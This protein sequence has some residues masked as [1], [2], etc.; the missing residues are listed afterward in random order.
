LETEGKL[1][2]Y[3]ASFKYIFSASGVAG[4]GRFLFWSA[5]LL[6][7]L[8]ATSA[9]APFA[10]AARLPQELA[11]VPASYSIREAVSEPQKRWWETFEDDELNG[12]IEEAFAGNQNLAS[13]WARL[14]KAQALAAKAG[15]DFIP[16][17]SGE[18]DA[19]YYRSR[20]TDNSTGRTVENKNYSL[21]LVAGYEIDLWGRIRAETQSAELAAAASRQDL[22]GAAV[23]IAA[24][25][26]ERWA[27]IIAQRQ[28]KN[29]L[30]KQL[31]ANKTYQDLVEL[32]FRKSLASALDV[33]QQRQLV[34]RVKAGIPL[35]EMEEQLLLNELS[36]LMG[37]Q[38]YDAPRFERYSLPD[39]DSPPA[40]GI[41]AR[42]LAFRPDIRAAYQRLAAADQDLAAARADRL[43]AL[44][45]T[46]S[47]AYSSDELDELFDNWLANF[48]A[49]L[50]APLID[51]GRRRAEVLY[52]ESAV[53]EQLAAYR[54]TVLTAVREVE[55]S[56]IREEK[57]RENIQGIENQLAAAR[58]AL[59][60][61]G[62]RYTNG[63]IDYLPVL[64]QLLS[65]QNLE[66]DLVARR[67]DLLIARI[68]LYR[69]IG[70]TWTDELE[71]PDMEKLSKTGN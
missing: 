14:I 58:T 26:A 41:P 23:T 67:T 71:P 52:S 15:A 8:L 18:A 12:F 37:R 44:R 4:S 42:L 45:L 47:A 49:G 20:N 27:R 60:E 54:Q 38:P 11:P 19:S 35:I 1:I 51:G 50:T 53:Q 36:V 68:D 24:E 63:L 43:P 34:E 65:V 31:Q 10:P 16:S 3:C 5:L 70:G 69:S 6:G 21:G 17:V 25:V 64:T 29:L 2:L 55:S 61:A 9:C 7:L 32:R 46:G 28:Q 62:F 40:A 33:M 48:A 13:Y 39:L 56:L 66:L 22:N 59:D 57:I 30:L